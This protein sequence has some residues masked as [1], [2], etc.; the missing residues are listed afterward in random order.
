VRLQFT[1]RERLQLPQTY[2]WQMIEGLP[3]RARVRPRQNAGVPELADR[4]PALMSR[5]AKPPLP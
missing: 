1:P 2:L 4:F 5:E 3:A